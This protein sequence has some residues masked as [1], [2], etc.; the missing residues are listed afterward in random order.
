[1]PSTTQSKERS[2]KKGVSNHAMKL[3]VP[4]TGGQRAIYKH[5]ARFQIVVCGRRWGKTELGKTLAMRE[6]SEPGKHVAWVSPTTK[7]SG[8]VWR[9]FLVGLSPI[10]DWISVQEKTIILNNFSKMTFWTAENYHTLRGQAFDLAILDEA[11]MYQDGEQFWN[12]VLRP[13]LADRH[14]KAYFL[15]TPAGRNWFYDLY[16]LGD[17]TYVKHHSAYQSWNFPSNTSPYFPED[18]FEQVKITSHERFFNQEYLAQFMIDAG[19]VFKGVHEVSILEALEVAY[20]GN[21]VIGIDLG[22]KHDATVIQVMDADTLTQVDMIILN[23]MDFQLQ[24]EEIIKACRKWNPYTVLVEENN[25][26]IALLDMFKDE[27]DIPMESFYTTAKSKKEI[28]E[29]LAVY[30][31]EK[32]IT[33]IKDPT[34][35]SELQAYTFKTSD[36]G[37]IKFGSPSGYHDDTVMSLAICLHAAKTS[38]GTFGAAIPMIA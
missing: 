5:P 25:F 17:P 14:G 28:I 2:G 26:G 34:Q 24:K 19:E 32:Y 33:L 13:A 9:E 22:R 7:M 10:A 29:D 36:S 30:I 3:H 35:I 15:S 11:A 37:N 16:L 20:E 27:H 12:G 31:R 1:M 23:A 21:F 6:L 8:E 38:S 18:E 4:H